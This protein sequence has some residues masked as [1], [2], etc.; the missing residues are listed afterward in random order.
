MTSE[1]AD[2][3]SGNTPARLEEKTP[4][5]ADPIGEHRHDTEEIDIS[6]HVVTAFS[7]PIPPPQ[8]LMGYKQI[9]S[10]LPDIIVRRWGAEQDHRHMQEAKLLDA[11]IRLAFLG[12]R[13]GAVL[14]V[15]AVIA[16][17]LIGMFGGSIAGP[18][19]A[20]TI[21]S[22]IGASVGGTYILKTIKDRRRVQN[23]NEE[24]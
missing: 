24:R 6:Q 9:D 19:A 3:S 4:E 23:E 16:A 18:A 2:N 15:C 7:G 17:A 14:V 5:T 1:I 8:V 12:Q 21:I 22:I 20:T 11:Q 10:S 13:Y